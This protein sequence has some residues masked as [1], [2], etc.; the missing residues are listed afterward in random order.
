MFGEFGLD[1]HRP[2]ARQYIDQQTFSAIL[3][4]IGCWLLGV[5]ELFRVVIATKLAVQN[6]R[7]VSWREVRLDSITGGVELQLLHIAQI[8]KLD[9]DYVGSS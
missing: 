4:R 5:L 8:M 2:I 3:P 9:A 6:M 1:E 7:R